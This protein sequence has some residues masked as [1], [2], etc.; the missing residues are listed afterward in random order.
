L[1]KINAAYLRMKNIQLGFSLPAHV[2]NR[3]SISS[4]R[5]YLSGENLFEF[6]DVKG[7]WDPESSST[8]F[9]YPFQ[10]TFSA[11]IDITF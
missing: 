6:H 4:A 8:G 1:Q 10:R 2:I 7:G 11:G 3:I 9:N 5:I